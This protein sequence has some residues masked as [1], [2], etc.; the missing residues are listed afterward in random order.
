MFGP[1]SYIAV[2]S[3]D[4]KVEGLTDIR[5]FANSGA[6]GAGAIIDIA[7]IPYAPPGEACDDD[8]DCL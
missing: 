8:I 1:A 6:G 2:E 4:L 7:G 5:I 3:S